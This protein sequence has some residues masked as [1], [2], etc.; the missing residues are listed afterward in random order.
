MLS[1]MGVDDG[2]PKLICVK[3]PSFGYSRML[4]K[5]QYLPNSPKKPTIGRRIPSIVHLNK[6]KMRMEM[7]MKAR[8][9]IIYKGIY[10]ENN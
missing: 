5:F 1:Y 10:N 7:K 3:R 6:M 4:H 8:V 2:S 9:F